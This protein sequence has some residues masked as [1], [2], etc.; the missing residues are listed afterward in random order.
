MSD[1]DRYCLVTLNR[2]SHDP[3]FTQGDVSAILLTENLSDLSPRL[4]RSPS[5]VKVNIPIPDEKI[6]TSFLN[7]IDKQNALMLDD[8]LTC[9]KVARITSG[10][11]LMNLNQLAAESFEEDRPIS[12]EYLKQRK[13][14]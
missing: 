1:E 5:T 2:W 14:R 10:L 6:R 9:D 4:V 13:K 7:F 12:L 11:N 3:I 8:R